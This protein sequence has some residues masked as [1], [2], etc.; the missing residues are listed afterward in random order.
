MSHRSDSTTT[1]QQ[2]IEL[3]CHQ[4]SIV[5]RLS[6]LAGRQRPLIDGG[7]TDDLLGLLAERQVL[8]DEFVAT[9]DDLGSLTQNL[10]TQRHAL[11]RSAVAGRIQRLARRL[12][13]VVA[14]DEHDCKLIEGGDR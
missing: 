9:S 7:R 5:D 2:V 1:E 12:D 6:A 8:I 10:Q 4:E 3:L 11:A 14:T 13:E